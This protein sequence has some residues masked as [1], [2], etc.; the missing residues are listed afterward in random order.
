MYLFGSFTLGISTEVFFGEM[1]EFLLWL[2]MKGMR[3]LLTSIKAVTLS[4]SI[5]PL[6]PCEVRT[7]QKATINTAP[8]TRPHRWLLYCRPPQQSHHQPISLH[9]TTNNFRPT[10]PT[11]WPHRHHVLQHAPPR[12]ELLRPFA[13]TSHAW[14][15]RVATRGHEIGTHVGR[16]GG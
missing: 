10:T 8:T 9:C 13:R 16:S 12:G 3:R 5:S 6:L 2:A 14:I 15:R 7:S 11:P 1:Y 4:W